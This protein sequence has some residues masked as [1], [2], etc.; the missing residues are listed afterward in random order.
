[1]KRDEQSRDLAYLVAMQQLAEDYPEDQDAALFLALAQLGAS[2]GGRDVAIYMQAAAIAEEVFAIN[3]R[4]P[5][6]AHYLVHSY[7][8][9][10]HA[11]L[12]LRAARVYADLSPSASHAQHMPSHIFYALG[13][14]PQATQSNIDAYVSD[15]DRSAERDIALSTHGYHAIWWLLYSQLPEGL[16]A[17]ALDTLAQAEQH[18]ISEQSTSLSR[19]IIVLMNVHYAVETGDWQHVFDTPGIAWDGLDGRSLAA[20]SYV[21]IMAALEDGDING[22]N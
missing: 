15:R 11:P 7:D 1:V 12:G 22:A 16:P 8:D 9:P 19:E 14:C 5:G 2:H 18:F 6:A 10:I 17:D 3:P 13:M 4:H 20:H 21:R